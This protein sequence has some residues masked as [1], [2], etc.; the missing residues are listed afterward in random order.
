MG[1]HFH[2]PALVS[3][4]VTI[5]LELAIPLLEQAAGSRVD[6]L[7]GEPDP[8]HAVEAALLGGRFDEVIIST[9]P[10]RVSHWLHVDL[11]ARV[12]RLGV[13]VT[14]ITAKQ[15]HRALFAAD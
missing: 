10:A 1:A 11:P 13:P 7:L 9:L 5:T 6:S 8:Y 14:V 15:A 3:T 12:Q 2:V 4:T